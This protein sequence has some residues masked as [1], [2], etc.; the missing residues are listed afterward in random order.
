MGTVLT[1]L[2]TGL[3]F[4]HQRIP[5]LLL[6]TNDLFARAGLDLD[7]HVG[8]QIPSALLAGVDGVPE[9]LLGWEAIR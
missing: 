1:A 3:A 2:G 8:M 4:D 7:G 9:F 6:D 5:R